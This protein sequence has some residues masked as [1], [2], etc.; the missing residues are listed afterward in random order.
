[1]PDQTDLIPCILER[2]IL[3]KVWGGRSLESVL[4][5]G[6]PA[7]ESVGETWE[8]YDRPDGSSA[9]RGSDKTLRNL[10]EQHQTDLLGRGVEPT[11]Q[12]FFPLLVKFIDAADRLSV[13][14]HPDAAMA[15]AAA[16]AT[17]ATGATE[18]N[19]AADG[20]KHEA[21]VVLASGEGG[22]IILGTKPGVTQEELAKVAHTAAVEDLLHAFRPQVGEAIYIPAGTIHTVGPDVVLFEIQENSDITYRLYDWGRP[23]ETQVDQALA[24]TAQAQENSVPAGVQQAERIAGGGEW[25]LRTRH[26]RVRRFKTGV[27][28]TLG[29]EGRFKI[30]TGIGGVGMLGWRS[31]GAHPPL[32]VRPGD[33]ALIPACAETV[34]LSPSGNW[35]F[36]WSDG[37]S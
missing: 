31:G 24:A 37:G 18:G 22:R 7:G 12:G 14:V 23:R 15:S 8:V 19:V 33:T 32:H 28:A 1:M 35:E 29:T 26:F 34:F 36:L 6:L 13:Q 16:K 25:L 20:G 21:W 2:K 27:P 5:I 4:G 10:M 9:I 30:L 11:P 3:P 17:G